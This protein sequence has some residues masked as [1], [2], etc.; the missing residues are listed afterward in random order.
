MVKQIKFFTTELYTYDSKKIILPNNVVA[1]S[2]IINYS[3]LDIRR[4]HRFSGALWHL[5]NS[6]KYFTKC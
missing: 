1:S 2:E 4:R 6:S 5:G 3:A